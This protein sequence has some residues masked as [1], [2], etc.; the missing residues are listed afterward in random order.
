MKLQRGINRH[1]E[2]IDQKSDRSGGRNECI[3]PQIESQQGRRADSAL[4]AYQPAKHSRQPPANHAV[5]LPKRMRDARP[6]I[7]M[8]PANTRRTPRT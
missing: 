4:I 2:E 6:V 5:R 7:P 8:N 1:A 3:A